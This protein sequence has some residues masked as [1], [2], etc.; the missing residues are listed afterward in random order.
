MLFCWQALFQVNQRH[1]W[2]ESSGHHPSSCTDLSNVIVE[3]DSNASSPGL[4]RKQTEEVT[5]EALKELLCESVEL[6][7]KAE[8]EKSRVICDK[9]KSMP[10]QQLVE[11][12]TSKGHV[13]HDTLNKIFTTIQTIPV[14]PPVSAILPAQSLALYN[15]NFPDLFAY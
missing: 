13:L 6:G 12:S 5:F 10:F 1:S 9:F 2:A 7:R 3:L 15:C 8:L 14:Q 11:S 4:P